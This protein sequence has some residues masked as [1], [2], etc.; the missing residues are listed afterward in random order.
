MASPSSG[1]RPSFSFATAQLSLVIDQIV[2]SSIREFAK[3]LCLQAG[4]PLA[5]WPVQRLQ[6]N[7]QSK[8]LCPMP[9]AHRQ[10]HIFTRDFF[11]LTYISFFNIIDAS[12]QAFFQDT[13]F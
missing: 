5:R 6:L 3:L 9:Y 2:N 8:I 1:L 4:C 13:A 7:L 12:K 10:E 11:P